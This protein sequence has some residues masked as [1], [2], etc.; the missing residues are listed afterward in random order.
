MNTVPLSL[1]SRLSSL[2]L[3]SESTQALLFLS[4]QMS[5][6]FASLCDAK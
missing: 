3:P 6:F 2:S 1:F 4:N 5:A